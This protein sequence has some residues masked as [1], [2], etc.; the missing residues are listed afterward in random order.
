MRQREAGKGRDAGQRCQIQQGIAEA[1]HP[2][3][4]HGAGGA[5]QPDIMG[6]ARRHDVETGR[7]PQTK[8]SGTKA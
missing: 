5:Y 7:G 3:Q 1:G 8:P 2:R 4:Y 6:G